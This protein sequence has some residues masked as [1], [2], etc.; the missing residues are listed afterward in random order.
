MAVTGGILHWQKVQGTDF[1]SELIELMPAQAVGLADW[2]AAGTTADARPGA[3][4]ASI[5]A[6]FLAGGAPAAVKLDP[7]VSLGVRTGSGAEVFCVRDLFGVEPLYYCHLPGRY[8]AFANEVEPLL[9]LPGMARRLNRLKAAVYLL[10]VPYDSFDASMTFFEGVHRLPPGHHLMASSAGVTVRRHFFPSAGE[11]WAEASDDELAEE[12]QSRLRR[13]VRRRSPGA[14]MLLSGGLKSSAL[15]ALACETLPTG[16]KLP[17]WAFVPVDVP[18]W[19]WPDDPR[20][21]LRELAAHARVD[22]HGVPWD[23]WGLSGEDDCYPDI[24]QQPLYFYIRDNEMTAM[25]AARRAGCG[26]L[27]TG[28][29]AQWLPLFR[30]PFGLAWAALRQGHWRELFFDRRNGRR[31]SAYEFAR[32]VR[33]DIVVPRVPAAWRRY[34]R[35]FSPPRTRVERVE[36]RHLVR[37]EFLA[38]TG[39]L[40]W[41]ATEAGRISTDF[42]ENACRELLRGNLQLQLENWSLQGRRQGLDLRHPFLD[43]EV[44]R[45]CL[46][47]PAHYYLRGEAQRVLRQAMRGLLPEPIRLRQGTIANITDWPYRKFVMQARQAARLQL[48]ERHPLLS[49]MLDLSPVHA[50]QAAIPPEAEVRRTMEERGLIGVGRLFTPGGVPTTVEYYRAFALFADRNGFA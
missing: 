6:A 10:G 39:A 31:R 38:E 45:F 50:A 8:F 41:F 1:P 48:L 2:P 20:P 30:P 44:A 37:K 5:R 47:L 35:G 34:W 32:L 18:G 23:G 46:E 19:N 3:S 42:R 17:A 29:G 22:W 9:A 12:L 24:R 11:P 40:D 14:G 43:A 26:A 21:S 25:A 15:A 7:E 28:M 4:V 13:A 33:R 49:T 27:L 16:G 36:H